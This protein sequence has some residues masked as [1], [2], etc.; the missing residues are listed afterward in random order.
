[1]RDSFRK[2]V[3]HIIGT[4][5]IVRTSTQT[6]KVRRVPFSSCYTTATATATATSTATDTG[7][8]KEQSFTVNYLINNLG[9]YPDSALSASKY[10]RL[11]N[12]EQPDSV[13]AFFRNYG[14][15]DSQLNVVFQKLPAVL[16]SN[17]TKT[18]SPKLHFLLSKGASTSQLIRIVSTNPIFLRRSLQNRS[19]PNFNLL[20]GFLQSDER[21]VLSIQRNPFLICSDTL[22]HQINFLLDAGFRKPGIVMLLHQWPSLLNCHI[23][24]L[25][26]KVGEVRKLGFDPSKS[27]F[28]PAMYAKEL[29][30]TTQDKKVELYKRWGWTDDAISKAFVKHPFCMLVSEQKI[31]EVF[32]FFVNHIGWE[33]LALARYPVFFSLSLRKRSIPRASVLQFLLSRDLIRSAKSKRPYVLTENMFLQNYVTKF[34]DE[35]PQ[36]LKLYEEKMNL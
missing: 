1:M 24:C 17:P 20:K 12:S 26:N 7:T 13:A 23:D 16:L 19:I 31:E 6:Q 36:L 33:P 15:S 30:K 8:S 21:T 14:F 3:F 34:K 28:V 25:R 27:N 5:V 35:A 10:I 11:K 18:L 4:L 2:S 22:Q 32:E 29:F 9:F